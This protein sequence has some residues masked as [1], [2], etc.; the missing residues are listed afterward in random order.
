MVLAHLPGQDSGEA[1][2]RILHGDVSPSGKLPYTIAQNE[3]DYGAT[4]KP[5]TPKR[6][7]Q[8]YPQDNFT[9]GV[10]IDYRAFDEG[11]IEPCFEFGFG[12]TYTTF[13]YSN[14]KIQNSVD[15]STLSPLPIGHII[16]GGHADL[17]DTIATVTA[18]VTNTGN[19]PA[20][21][22][23]Q[24]YLTIPGE[25][26]LIRQLRGFDKVVVR[27]GETETFE[28]EL[29]RRDLSVWDVAA[30][31]WRLLTGSDYHLSVGASSRKLI[32]NGTLSL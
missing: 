26:Q 30:Q 3:L 4:L 1:I 14:L 18:D 19:V 32:L 10:Y 17:W 9:E 11:G 22:V 25:G 20:A 27:P 6:W 2:T 31:Q 16:P 12:L 13:E 15:P 24:L 8:Y 21:E 23:G 5:Y 28:F 29:R 7:D